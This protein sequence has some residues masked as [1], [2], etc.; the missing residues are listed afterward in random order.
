MKIQ[1]K[2]KRKWNPYYEIL[3]EIIWNSKV[4]FH[5]PISTTN[6][7]EI[8]S[9][10]QRSSLTPNTAIILGSS[11]IAN[12]WGLTRCASIQSQSQTKIGDDREDH[13]REKKSR[14]E[15]ER[16]IEER[17]FIPLNLWERWVTFY[18]MMVR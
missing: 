9:F 7:N 8:E 1:P 18:L 13:E 2:N 5:S 10:L 16:K 17:N 6:P 12:L 4:P 14:E 11:L 15:Y 3:S